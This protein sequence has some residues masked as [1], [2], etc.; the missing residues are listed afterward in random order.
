VNS[1]QVAHERWRIKSSR[2]ETKLCTGSLFPKFP[3][4]ERVAKNIQESWS[5]RYRRT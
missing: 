5:G 3:G 4:T 2:V 1:S